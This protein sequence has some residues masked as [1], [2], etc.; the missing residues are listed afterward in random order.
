MK[1]SLSALLFALVLLSSLEALGATTPN[2]DK[3]RV[4]VTKFADKTAR[5]ASYGSGCHGY[6]A[7]ADS[8]GNAFSDVLVEKLEANKRVDVLERGSIDAIY[9]K[10]V[11]LVNS[12]DDKSINRGKFQKAQITFIGVVDGFE[13]CENG[14]K[15][16][17]NVGSLFGLGDI[18]PTLKSSNASIS[19]LIRA[20]NATTGKVLA[21][22]RSKKTQSRRGVSITAHIDAIDFSGADFRQTPLGE[23]V[24][25]VIGEAS[26][27]LIS[28]LKL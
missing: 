23:T 14:T 28:K 26:E 6:Y 21:T 5:G 10:E 25:E 4:S 11:T 17:V 24:Q 1:S 2:R 7:W 19:V 13:Y 16:A 9:E 20:V 12:E 27:Q 8:L 15:A 22:A 3:V 18:T